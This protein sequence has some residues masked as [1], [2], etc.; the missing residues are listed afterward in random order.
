MQLFARLH[1]GAESDYGGGGSSS[2]TNH[3]LNCDED[4]FNDG[5]DKS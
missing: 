4:D 1:L 5:H 3:C 2:N